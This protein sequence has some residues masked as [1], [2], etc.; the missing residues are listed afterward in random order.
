M[1]FAEEI[2]ALRATCGR[3]VEAP[4]FLFWE[5][6]THVVVNR[7]F[8][9]VEMDGEIPAYEVVHLAAFEPGGHMDQR[10]LA[11]PGFSCHLVLFWGRVSLTKPTW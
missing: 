7:S 3:S 5:H 6:F 4:L 8:T 1:E 9:G 10:S 11:H 2:D